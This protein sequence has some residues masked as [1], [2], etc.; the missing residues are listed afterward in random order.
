MAVEG[1]IFRCLECDAVTDEGR[2]AIC[3]VLERRPNL[4]CGVGRH[5]FVFA[6]CARE[7]RGSS[8]T[9][10]LRFTFSWSSADAELM[11]RCTVLLFA[12]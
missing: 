3:A 10:K 1:S 6:R 7:A 12:D 2:L 8:F 9:Q 4:A 5:A 11:S